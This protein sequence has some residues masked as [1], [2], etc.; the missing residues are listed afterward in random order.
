MR[1]KV[2]ISVNYRIKASTAH[3]QKFTITTRES[4][5]KQLLT[6]YQLSIIT[7]KQARNLRYLINVSM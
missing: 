6:R 3:Y 1:R 7:F 2:L 4:N 5:R